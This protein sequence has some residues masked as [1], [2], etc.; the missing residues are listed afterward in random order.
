VL[1]LR[2]EIVIGSSTGG[3]ELENKELIKGF[4][5]G[6]MIIEVGINGF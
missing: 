3:I 5:N 1:L 6:Y 2:C 4:Q